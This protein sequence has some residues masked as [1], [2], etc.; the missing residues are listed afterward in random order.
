MRSFFIDENGGYYEGDQIDLAHQQ[1]S[2]R[3]DADHVLSGGVWVQRT[4]SQAEIDRETAK[5]EVASAKVLPKIAAFKA[6]TRQQVKA[7]AAD[8]TKRDDL[9][10]VLALAVWTY[11][12]N[13]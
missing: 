2:R 8:Q 9:L 7:M 3:P 6:M 13:Q 5:S 11:L 1:V 12:N 10:E 4:K